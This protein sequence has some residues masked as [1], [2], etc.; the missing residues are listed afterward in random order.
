MGSQLPMEPL[1]TLK[2]Q[3]AI[4]EISMEVRHTD[5]KEQGLLPTTIVADG[6]CFPRTLSML[7]YG[8]QFHFQ[9]MR[10][11]MMYEGV[12]N[13]SEYLKHH[14]LAH[15]ARHKY[16]KAKLM[17][18]FAQ[19]SDEY[20]AGTKTTPK[21]VKKVLEKELL[22]VSKNSSYCGIWQCFYGSECAQ[23]AH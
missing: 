1:S 15:G 17:E 13:F 2:G 3:I 10:G 6:N 14:Y 18:I 7:V 8:N 23:K 12:Q 19:Y 9:E 4:D 22:S 11:R 5:A 20:V 21:L 16:K